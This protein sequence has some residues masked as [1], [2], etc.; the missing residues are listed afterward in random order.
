MLRS[1][2]MPPAHAAQGGLQPESCCTAAAV[3]R[4][5]SRS[6][7]SGGVDAAAATGWGTV[8]IGSAGHPA[9]SVSTP[10]RTSP[11]PA[12]RDL[13]VP[14]HWA[15][16]ISPSSSPRSSNGVGTTASSS[17]SRWHRVREDRRGGRASVAAAAEASPKE[18]NRCCLI[19][20]EAELGAA[21]D[22]RAS[23]CCGEAGNLAI[24]P[25]GGTVRRLT[26]A[27]I[28]TEGL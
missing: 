1:V 20:L 4:F 10:S 27:S 15:P 14:Q 6:C 18:A 21:P 23:C 7:R 24:A 9:R 16:P 11:P 5:I 26:A 13:G 22:N 25:H 8:S 19:L 28:A 2:R 17:A 3:E 12:A